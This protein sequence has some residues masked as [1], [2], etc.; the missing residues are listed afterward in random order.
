M[1]SKSGLF[2]GIGNTAYIIIMGIGMPI[3]KNR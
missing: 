3:V 2:K 1:R